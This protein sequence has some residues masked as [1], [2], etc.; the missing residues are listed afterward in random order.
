MFKLELLF[1]AVALGYFQSVYYKL[2]FLF[3]LLEA[4][5]YFDH[6]IR[7]VANQKSYK[8]RGLARNLVFNLIRTMFNE[9]FRHYIL[10]DH[11]PM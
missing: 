11:L 9:V 2:M 8:E 6:F 4:Y 10:Q 1:F 3:Y 5:E 7:I